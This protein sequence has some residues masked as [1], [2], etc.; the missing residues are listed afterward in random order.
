MSIQTKNG[1]THQGGGVEASYGSWARKNVA[2]EIGGVSTDNSVDYFLAGNYFDENGW[3]DSSPTEVKQLFG[4]LGWQNEATRVELSYTGADNN[5]IGNGL[6]QKELMDEFGRAAI[7]TKPD[8]T[9]NKLSFFNLNGSHWFNDDVQLSANT[10]YRQS[11]RNTL[12]GDVN[13][14]FDFDTDA[15]GD[16]D[17]AELAAAI[18]AC[19][20]ADGADEDEE[21]SGALNRSRT[22]QKGYG[23][24]T[25]L[26]FNQPLMQKKNQLIVGLG[27]DYS[28]IK[29]NQS[30]EYGIVN[31]TRGIDGV[32]VANT[33]ADVNLHGKTDSW[34][35]FATDTL[36]LT[37]QWHL[38][39]SGRYNHIKVKNT[40]Q[41]NPLGTFV[42][43]DGPI[44]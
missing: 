10:Y 42:D 17:A 14:D 12:N 3:R 18:A 11:K 33:D 29:F 8:Q 32:G 37:D 6:V 15:S 25:Q 44:L 36:S 19:A 28:K 38:T 31:T 16:V 22:S 35:I 9:E 5:M 39:M 2:A 34:G 30:S 13:D 41:I 27:Y 7:N 24:N 26:A 23:F 40:D 4:K 21:C 1:R 20:V 43:V